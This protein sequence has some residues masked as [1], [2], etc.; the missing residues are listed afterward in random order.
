MVQVTDSAGNLATQPLTLVIPFPC[1]VNFP[2]HYPGGPNSGDGKPTSEN[3]TFTPSNIIT[4]LPAGLDAAALA[5][6]FTAFNWQQTV[7]EDPDAEYYFSALAPTTPLTVP[8]PDPPP[9]GYTYQATDPRLG[10]IP[11]DSYPFYYNLS[12]PMSYPL[13]LAAIPHPFPEVVEERS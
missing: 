4:G 12:A 1:P 7:N 8:Y 2:S 9:G 3:A 5:C 11:N 6:G 10:D 13:S